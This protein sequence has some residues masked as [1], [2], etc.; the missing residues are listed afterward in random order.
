MS[1]AF[2]QT[3]QVDSSRTIPYCGAS[4][5]QYQETLAPETIPLID[6][7]IAIGYKLADIC[8]E[9]DGTISALM[10]RQDE[11]FSVCSTSTSTVRCDTEI[12]LSFRS[13]K[14]LSSH[15]KLNKSL[16][17][18]SESF[19][20]FCKIDTIYSSANNKTAAILCGNPE[21]GSN[22]WFQVS[23]ITGRVSTVKAYSSKLQGYKTLLPKALKQFRTQQPTY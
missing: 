13:N 3:S 15:V 1:Q 10:Y 5:T 23:R 22:T 2:A 12:L 21:G 6:Q 7:Y 11:P 4:I 9:G 18:I 16:D 17:L 20:N 19:P 14:T 8:Q